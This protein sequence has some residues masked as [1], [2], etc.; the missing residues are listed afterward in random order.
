MLLL[1]KKRDTTAS[2]SLCLLRI[3][4][5]QASPSV[6]LS[7]SVYFFQARH[8]LVP[9]QL[10]S[11]MCPFHLE[12]FLGLSLFT[13]LVLSFQNNS[14]TVSLGRPL[15]HPGSIRLPYPRHHSCCILVH[16]SPLPDNSSLKVGIL[17]KISIKILLQ[18]RNK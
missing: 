4:C 13:E 1:S 5:A 17:N 2:T 6:H 12:S 8:S 18:L 7:S 14:S 3:F 11:H 9:P 16:L 10:P 15:T